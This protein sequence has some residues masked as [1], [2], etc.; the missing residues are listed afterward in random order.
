MTF[1]KLPAVILGVSILASA[2]SGCSPVQN[3]NGGSHGSR[4]VLY[5][6]VEE[7]AADSASVVIG[8]VVSQEVVADLEGS[9]AMFT[10][11]T[12]K[13]SETL[14]DLPLGSNL[15][16]VGLPI[17]SNTEVTVRQIGQ[18][19]DGSSPTTILRVG[20]EYLLFL[21]PSG[22]TGKAASHFYVTGGNAGLY[23]RASDADA[24]S[25]LSSFVQVDPEEG[26]RLPAQLSENL[27][28]K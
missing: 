17:D 28:A 13:V 21:T 4:A 23:G 2:L 22:L 16:K 5:D 14:D 15:S 8:T 24:K 19:E 27:A 11:S 6:S 25:D 26:E 3:I 12:L 1:N 9:E 18:R 10:L 20:E 7:L